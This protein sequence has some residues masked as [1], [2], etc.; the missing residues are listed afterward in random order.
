MKILSSEFTIGNKRFK[1]VHNTFIKKSIHS[2]RDTAT[3][4]LPTSAR[5]KSDTTEIPSRL[6]ATEFSVG[7]KVTIKLGYGD[8][9]RTEFI[10]FV[11]RVN[12]SQPLEL[13]C[14]GYSWLLRFECN[15]T[16]SWARTTLKEVLSEVIRVSNEGRAAADQIKL[17]PGIPDLPLKNIV[18]NNA[19]GV[20]VIDYIK[21]LFNGILQAFFID[22][23]LYMG[24]SYTDVQKSTVKYR[25]NWNTLP[26]KNLNYRLANETIVKIE[27]KFRNDQGQQITTTTG[28]SGGIT[29]RDNLTVVTD[30]TTIQKV[31]EAKLA[32]ESFDGYEGN[33][34]TMLEPYCQPGYRAEI[35]DLQ[36]SQRSGNYFTESTAVTFG[37]GG[38]KRTIE[39][40]IKLS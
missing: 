16:K 7:D 14:E 6:T 8:K 9:L 17:H 22:E 30:V 28:K 38:A 40:G 18:I 33:I 27:L 20:Q 5:L 34:T 19:T 32:L 10:G 26:P 13:E 3:I 31:A 23:Q 36:Y 24:L 29:K 35:T 15:V 39:L 4:Q 2:Y 25:L 1:G 37:N 21:G 11:S 12:F